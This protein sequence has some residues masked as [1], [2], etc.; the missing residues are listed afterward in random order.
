M[1]TTVAEKRPLGALGRMGMVAGLHVAALYLIATGLGIVPPLIQEPLVGT[2]IDEVRPP[3][4]PHPAVPQPRLVDPRLTVP[5]PD[6]VNIDIALPDPVFG[7]VTSDPPPT[8]E[9][10]ATGPDHTLLAARMDTRHPL[11]QPTYPARDIREGNEG[12]VELEIY[13]LPTGRIGDARVLKSTGSPT[14]DQSAVEEA[15]R[16][17]RMLPATRDGEPYAQWHRLKVTF[18]LRNR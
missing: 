6:H 2:V 3:D 4:D 14:L 10:I 1:N 18:N 11:T 16:K 17:W 12:T 7:E 15:K 5:P 9:I 8:P 13:V